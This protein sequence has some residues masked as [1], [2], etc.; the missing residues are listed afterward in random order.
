[1]LA[2]FSEPGRVPLSEVGGDLA[3]LLVSLA[4]DIYAGEDQSID[5][6]GPT[7]PVRS[8]HSCPIVSEHDRS[9]TDRVHKR[10][11]SIAALLLASPLLT[12]CSVAEGGIAGIGVDASGH[13]VAY[14]QM[15]QGYVDGAV[16]FHDNDIYGT[17]KA[18]SHQDGFTSFSLTTPTGAWSPGDTPMGTLDPAIKYTLYGSTQDASWSSAEVE[19]T[20]HTVATMKPGQVR[21]YIDTDKDHILDTYTVTSVEE[22]KATVCKAWFG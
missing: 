8:R 5:A 11:V 19:F 17:W 2:E 15:C 18:G 14:I 12:G 20:A 9:D 4:L 3:T 10:L 22:F 13:P 7:A 16:L 21:Y 6:S 1:V